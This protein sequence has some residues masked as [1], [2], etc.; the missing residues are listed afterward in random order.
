MSQLCCRKGTGVALQPGEF[1]AFYGRM[2][3]DC[4]ELFLSHY[5]RCG[6]IKGCYGRA[7]QQFRNRLGA[8]GAGIVRTGHGAGVAAIQ[9]P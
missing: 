5:G 6:G 4:G 2:G 3:E 7:P 8:G 1:G 9:R